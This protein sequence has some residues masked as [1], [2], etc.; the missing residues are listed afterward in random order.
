MSY[1]VIIPVYWGTY[2]LIEPYMPYIKKHLGGQKIVLIGPASMREK[3]PAMEGV[4]FLD[5][6]ALVQGMSKETVSGVIATICREQGVP[7]AD[8]AGWYFQQFIKMSYAFQCE[9]EYY[10][11][12]DMDTVPLRD[13]PF[14]SKEDGK[15][16]FFERNEDH[17]AYF[18]TLNTLCPGKIK[19]C[20]QARSF[21]NQFMIFKTD[22]MKELVE[23]IG[24]SAVKGDNWWEKILHAV[25]PNDITQAGFSE[26]E[27]YGNYTMQ[28]H[29]QLYHI[30]QID[31]CR[32]GASFLTMRP[33]KTMMEWAAR[34]YYCV[35]LEEWSMDT[36]WHNRSRR[37]Y[38]ILPMKA[39]VNL[40]E[41]IYTIKRKVRKAVSL[42]RPK[43]RGKDG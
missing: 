9:A 43:S 21:V 3:L 5:G 15:P 27:T 42:I 38:K 4:A 29:P 25:D 17:E 35:T 11:S 2:P 13:I 41:W 1:H 30:T 23:M 31:Q 7:F 19:K 28:Y 26:F 34:S 16:Q 32:T 37:L 18:T 10:V 24:D 14:F 22:I 8:R 12:W 39:L 20:R 36:K 40:S 33:E 6:N